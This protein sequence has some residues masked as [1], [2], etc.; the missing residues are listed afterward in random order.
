MDGM[1]PD[2]VMTK[3]AIALA[4]F[5]GRKKVIKDDIFTVALLSLRHRTRKGGALGPP[6]EQEILKVLNGIIKKN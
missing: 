6:S 3:A 2:I 5:R 4:A 1:R